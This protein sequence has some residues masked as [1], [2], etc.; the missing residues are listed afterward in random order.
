LRTTPDKIYASPVAGDGKVYFVTEAGVVVVL[1]AGAERRVVSVTELGEDTYATPA[2]S[3][4][5]VYIRTV[6]ALHAF[7]R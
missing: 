4:G 3:G 5:R 1:A 2:I 7:G 6:Q